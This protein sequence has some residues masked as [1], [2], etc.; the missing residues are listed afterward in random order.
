L[1]FADLLQREKLNGIVSKIN[2]HM[3]FEVFVFTHCRV[4]QR[5][6]KFK[7]RLCDT[8]CIL[9]HVPGNFAFIVQYFLLSIYAPNLKSVATAVAGQKM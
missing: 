6:P 7:G 3:K 4:T 8:G 2:V 9:F 1:I 5:V